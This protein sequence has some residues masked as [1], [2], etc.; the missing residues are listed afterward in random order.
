MART[1]ERAI[2]LLRAHSKIPTITEAT[3]AGV[4]ENEGNRDALEIARK[5]LDR[6][7]VAEVQHA[8]TKLELEDSKADNSKLTA[9]NWTTGWENTD[10]QRKVANLEKDNA[11][12]KKN[13]TALAADVENR[14]PN[15]AES[16]A[17]EKAAKVTAKRGAG[18]RDQQGGDAVE[19]PPSK[20]A[21]K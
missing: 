18:E 20:R 9:D 4:A 19:T 8:A 16:I 2:T 21:K 3:I 7:P 11:D 1:S 6:F 13:V 10:L 12:L 17:S 15:L 5:L 14:H